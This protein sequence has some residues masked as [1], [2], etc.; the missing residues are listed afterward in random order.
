MALRVYNTAN[1]EIFPLLIPSQVVLIGQGNEIHKQEGVFIMRDGICSRLILKAK[2][3]N[4][5]F[6]I[7]II[8][9]L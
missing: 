6:N 7:A 9:H 5:N 2:N 8:N 4:Y 3:I 1:C